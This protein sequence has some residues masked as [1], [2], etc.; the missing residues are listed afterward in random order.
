M[1][2]EEIIEFLI[3]ECYIKELCK[4]Q[5]KQKSVKLRNKVTYRS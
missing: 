4:S 1:S 5:E 2:R 3:R